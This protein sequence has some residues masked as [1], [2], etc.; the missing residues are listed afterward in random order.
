MP[1]RFAPPGL[2]TLALIRSARQLSF[3][4]QSV[5]FVPRKFGFDIRC[6]LLL[7]QVVDE[8]SGQL[9]EMAQTV[10]RFASDQGFEAIFSAPLRVGLQ[11][12]LEIIQR[13]RMV[14]ASD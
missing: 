8:S 7:M 9:G 6:S 4:N 3:G 10:I 13:P 12:D 1:G 2:T 14:I 11:F 5:N